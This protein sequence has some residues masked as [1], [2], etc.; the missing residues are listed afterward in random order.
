LAGVVLLVPEVAL[1]PHP[2]A[3]TVAI[4]YLAP[5]HLLAAVVVVLGIQILMEQPEMAVLAAVGGN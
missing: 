2:V 4:Q 5:L 1:P 3:L